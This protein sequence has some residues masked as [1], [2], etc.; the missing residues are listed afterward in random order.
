MNAMWRTHFE[1]R[2]AAWD[3][4]VARRRAIAPHDPVADG[5]AWAAEE[6]RATLDESQNDHRLLTPF[7]WGRMQSPP[8]TAQTVTRWIRNGELPATKRGRSYVLTVDAKRRS[9]RAA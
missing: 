9:A 8:V 6:V 2:L 4:E 5:I 1:N 3:A 7:A